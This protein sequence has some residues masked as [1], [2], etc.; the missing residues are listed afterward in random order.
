MLNAVLFN[1]SVLNVSDTKVL[2]S[3]LTIY[4]CTSDPILMRLALD[5]NYN[6]SA[7]SILT[8]SAVLIISIILT[9]L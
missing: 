4:D 7:T 8:E 3:S 2:L 9:Y 6:F 5:H 1:Y